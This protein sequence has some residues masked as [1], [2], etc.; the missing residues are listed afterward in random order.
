M[1]APELV[2]LFRC[3]RW[4]RIIADNERR[5]G[6]A[7]SP[8]PTSRF[9]GD[10]DEDLL[11][12]MSLRG[13]D[14]AA[15]E[16]AWAEFYNRHIGY[17]FAQCKR[18]YV[19]ALG[20]L[21]VRDLTQDTFVRAYE[22]AGAFQTR[23]STDHEAIRRRVRGWLGKIANRLFLDAFRA[24]VECGLDEA[25]SPSGESTVADVDCNDG[26]VSLR[27]K[28]IRK[29]LATL[30]ERERHVLRVTADWHRCDRMHQR[31]SK[32][33]MKVLADQLQTTAVN[34]RQIRKRAIDKIRDYIRSHEQPR[35]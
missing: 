4:K 34:I 24:P 10:N 19:T 12:Y 21:G 11:V 9:S 8:Q 23:G 35:K 20:D 6:S 15:A 27:T 3:S 14:P 22:K 13:E 25:T 31:V 32:A 1:L 33:D 5:M 7:Q 29:A 17:V 2:T 16:E 30:T 18:A 26:R 28:L